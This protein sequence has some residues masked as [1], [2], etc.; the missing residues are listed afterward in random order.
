L[1]QQDFSQYLSLRIKN[2]FSYKR[3]GDVII[4]T[5]PAW[6]DGYEAATHGTGYT[7]D[8]HVPLLLFGAGIHKGESFEHYN[9]TDLAPTISMLLR[10][11]L[12]NACMGDPI[13]KALG[14]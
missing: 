9:I 6:T 12:P 13:I 3:S 5:E 14:E 11:K 4:V 7:Y 8:T 1:E 10:I 2:G